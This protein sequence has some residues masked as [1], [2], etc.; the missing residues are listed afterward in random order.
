MPTGIHKVMEQLKIIVP[1]RDKIVTV[2]KIVTKKTV[3]KLIK[4]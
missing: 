3:K 1:V 2:D 4:F